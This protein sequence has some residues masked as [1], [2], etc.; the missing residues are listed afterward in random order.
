MIPS[1]LLFQ[2]SVSFKWLKRWRVRRANSADVPLSPLY[3]FHLVDL[4]F[5]HYSLMSCPIHDRCTCYAASLHYTASL[6]TTASSQLVPQANNILVGHGWPSPTST[7]W[8]PFES[9]LIPPPT[10]HSGQEISGAMPLHNPYYPE[11]RAYEREQKPAPSSRERV[12]FPSIVHS[13]PDLHKDSLQPNTRILH[14]TSRV[15]PG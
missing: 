4:E 8:Y 9:V 2:T 3:I 15:L 12:R 13:V 7:P 1:R 6:T 14:R 10:S 11:P 5:Y